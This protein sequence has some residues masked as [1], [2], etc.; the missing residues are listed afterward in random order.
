M[1]KNAYK[2]LLFLFYVNLIAY[3]G[4]DLFWKY[5]D[6]SLFSDSFVHPQSADY[7]SMIQKHS[8][9]YGLDWRFVTSMIAAESSFK[10]DAVSNKGAVGLMQVLPAVAHEHGVTNISDP[11]TNIRIGIK[12]FKHYF[13]TFKGKT[14]DDTLKISLAAYNAGIAHV[15]DAQK[16]AIYMNLNPHEWASLEKTFPYLENTDFHTFVEYGFCQG[17]S[18]VTYVNKVYRTYLKN[19]ELYP[20][21]PDLDTKKL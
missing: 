14:P 3:V 17:N 13:D 8:Q 15:L 18:V 19:R 9:R 6:H 16:L 7:E 20:A 2:I 10:I 12:H 5:V 21:F 11:E 4:G 1:K